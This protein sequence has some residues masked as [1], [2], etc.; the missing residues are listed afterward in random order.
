MDI[1]GLFWLAAKALWSAG[2]VLGLSAIAERVNTRTAGILAGAPI[3]SVL[4]YLFVGL[5]MGPHY[6]VESVP[7]GI[8]AFTATLAFVIGYHRGSVWFGRNAAPL[9]ALLGTGAFGAVALAL[10]RVPFGIAS[11]TAMTLAA[12]GLSFWFFRT[13]EFVRVE[14]PVRY[15]FRLMLLRAS[16]AALLV[17]GA[18]KV[19]EALGPRW[20]GLMA[21][22]PATLL[23]T[24]L[25]LH[26]TYG[27]PQAL[28][29]IRNFPLGLGSIVLFI[30]SVSFTFPLVG[31][32]Y[33]TLASLMLSL[34]Y[35]ML[36]VFWRHAGAPKL[37]RN[38]GLRSV[39]WRSSSSEDLR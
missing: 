10:V 19:A 21:G 16:G 38:L 32:N 35:L 2:I 26:F 39:C 25:I 36:V 15:T 17:I 30:L 34:T 37:L 24:L 23:P 22:F 27:Q 11:A 5:E 29:V 7:H 18:I 12:A 4:V 1:P 13:I 20:T 28:A 6:V 33:G 8:A 31:V 9:C 14:R 3:T